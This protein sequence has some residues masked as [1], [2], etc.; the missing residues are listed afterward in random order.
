MNRSELET[1]L[2]DDESD[3]VERTISVT[4]SDKFSEAICAFANDMPNAGKPGYLF[5]AATPDGKASG[6]AITDELLQRLAAIRSD[7]NIQPL[8]VMNV[9]KWQLGGGDMAV[10]EVFP[11]DLPPVRYRGRT[12]IRVGPRR[13]QAN[14]A[15]ERILSERRIDRA[16][17]WDARVCWEAGL[18]D[19]ALDRFTLS[20]RL[21]AVAYDVVE[22]N[23]RPLDLQLASLRFY[24]LKTRPSH[25]CRCPT[26]RQGSLLVLP[27][28]LRAIRPVLRDLP[29]RRSPSGEEDRGRPAGH[30]ARP[31]SARP[32]NRRR[33]TNPRPR[34]FGNRRLRL[35]AQGDAGNPHER[36]DP[37]KLRGLDHTDHD[38]SLQ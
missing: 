12:C 14:P 22:E 11:S 3:R 24:D 23:D 13:A 8:P 20:Y 9:Q 10:V 35:P 33:K 19:L 4:D 17:T 32:R 16:R 25:E 2:A 29:G 31:Q 6:A 5:I 28:R 30:P 27:W 37:S 34:S 26:L 38:Q 36:G 15:E 1:L 21:N 7:G 18:D